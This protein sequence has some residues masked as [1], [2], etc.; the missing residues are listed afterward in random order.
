MTDN[1]LCDR[2]LAWM[3]PLGPIT[4][5][6]LS[7]TAVWAGKLEEH[8][9]IK[10]VG[11]IQAGLPPITVRPMLCFI[12]RLLHTALRLGGTRLQ[13]LTAVKVWP[14]TKRRNCAC[15]AFQLC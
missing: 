9:G 13:G 5:A 1:V 4:V 10:V 14:C 7:V 12:L 6:T 15:I 3:G 11:P 8:F 2:R